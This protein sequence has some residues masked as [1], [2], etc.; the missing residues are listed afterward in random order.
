MLKLVSSC[1]LSRWSPA[2]QPT[3]QVE[4]ST[5]VESLSGTVGG[6]RYGI[7]E[8]AFNPIRAQVSVG[9][10]VRFL[11]NGGS[12]TRLRRETAAGRPVPLSQR[13]LRT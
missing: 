4:T 1:G 8:H 3:N 12:R 10:R 7:E 6:K 11:N 2:V 13:C 9:A 5:L